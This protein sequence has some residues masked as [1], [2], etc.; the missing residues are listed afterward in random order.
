LKLTLVRFAYLDQNPL[1]YYILIYFNLAPEQL[2][3]EIPAV[4]DI[5]FSSSS[6]RRKCLPFFSKFP[7]QN[8]PF[9]F[10]SNS[11]ICSIL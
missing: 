7:Q 5:T 10:N 11:E 2:G 6:P 3:S 4:P 8:L 1:F 9:L